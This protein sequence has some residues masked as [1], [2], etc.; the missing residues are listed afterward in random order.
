MIF[1]FVAIESE[2]FSI[3]VFIVEILFSPV[4]HKHLLLFTWLTKRSVCFSRLTHSLIICAHKFHFNFTIIWLHLCINVSQCHQ[5]T[6]NSNSELPLIAFE[7]M[8]DISFAFGKYVWLSLIFNK[9][10]E[11]VNCFVFFVLFLFR[12]KL[13]HNFVRQQ[14]N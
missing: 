1:S 3:I 12:S 7:F 10:L 2:M 9:L 6:R 13:V 5:K 11:N 14:Q 8:A 4:P